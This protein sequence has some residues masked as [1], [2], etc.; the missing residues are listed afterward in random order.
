MYAVN[1]EMKC[2]VGVIMSIVI[3]G[4]MTADT[5]LASMLRVTGLGVCISMAIKTAMLITDIDTIG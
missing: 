3:E 2:D 1:H 4:R 5:L